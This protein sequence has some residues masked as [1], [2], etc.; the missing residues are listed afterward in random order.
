V[1]AAVY[2]VVGAPGAS[3]EE[4]LEAVRGAWDSEARLL[5]RRQGEAPALAGWAVVEGAAGCGAKAS[6]R[7]EVGR[8]AAGAEVVVVACE[9]A[10][11]PLAVLQALAA[12]GEGASLRAVVS[13]WGP[14]RLEAVS[15]EA[16][17]WEAL[18]HQGE[19]AREAVAEGALSW[20]EVADVVLG[21]SEEE[22]ARVR[23]LNPEAALVARGGDAGWAKEAR[24]SLGAS[25]QRPGWMRA[26]KGQENHE[27]WRVFTSH[28]PFHPGRLRAVMEA[29]WAGLWRVRG[30]VWLATQMKFVGQWSASG[31]AWSLRAS[32]IWWADLPR[33]RW[34]QRGPMLAALE[35]RWVEPWGD[36]RQEVA[37]LCEADARPALLA[38]LEAALLDEEEMSLGQ[39]GWRYLHDPLR[40]L[41]ARGRS[42][43]PLRAPS[44][45]PSPGPCYHMGH[46][47]HA[48]EG[49]VG[50]DDA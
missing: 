35:A 41:E 39:L 17:R 6:L 46:P 15:E 48:V 2:V 23:A 37:L 42:E 21:V 25:M 20:L 43:G 47:L 8:A 24:A 40:G 13:V 22:R 27:P 31:S 3:L 49:G 30:F 14:G 33:E 19:G 34:P 28:R 18:G 4:A 29:R 1:E 26:L 50:V 11:A 44:P 36:R 5:W 12:P 45:G 38:A 10:E 9:E 16:R 32:G 7:G